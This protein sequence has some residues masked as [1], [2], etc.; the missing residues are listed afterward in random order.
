[1]SRVHAPPLA[2]LIAGSALSLTVGW[3]PNWVLSTWLVPFL[4]LRFG[5]TVA[6]PW[7]LPPLALVGLTLAG[8]STVRGAWHMGASTEVFFSA[9]MALPLVVGVLADRLAARRLPVFPRTLVF[10]A[11]WTLFDY[12]YSFTYGLGDV[13]S[14]A[15]TQ[16]DVP[17]LVQLVSLTGIYGLTFLIGWVASIAATVADAPDDLQS[18]RGPVLA[19]GTALLAVL[20]YGSIRSSGF[21]HDVPT[22]RVA[23]VVIEHPRDFWAD[24]VDQGNRPADLARYAGD[25][26]EVEQAAFTASEQAVA[27][28]ADIVFWAEATVPMPSE[29]EGRFKSR[30]A[31]FAAQHGVWLQTAGLS[32]YA[33]DERVDNHIT[34]FGPDG[35][36][37]Y[38]YLKTQTWY[39]TASDGIIPATQTPFGTLSSVICFDLDVPGWMG[40]VADHGADILLVPG[41]D[42]RPIAPFHTEAGLFRAVEGGYSIVRAVAKGTSM[43]V[44]ATGRTLLLTDSFRTREP[45]FY[46]DVPVRGRST[47]Y[48]WLGDWFV[49]VT[50]L[51]LAGLVMGA[52]RRGSPGR[53]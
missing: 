37:R 45:V 29:D 36:E 44:D 7:A 52:V 16:F 24:I 4:L 8:W 20:G 6:S 32:M 2:F 21:D 48:G 12:A 46:V 31:D 28:G 3:E 30:A 43:A 14:P 17:L 38:H 15:L 13:F 50:A 33:D 41:F 39:P 27:A 53:H 19:G 11:V 18:W 9:V 35:E 51:L 23:G 26:A 40:Q 1:M 42:T 10:P 34:L 49:G 5:R 25:F 22:A 47:V